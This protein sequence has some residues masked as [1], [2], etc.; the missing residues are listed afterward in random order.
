MF[1]P[2]TS[3]SAN[4]TM[5]CTASGTALA[6]QYMNIGDVTAKDPDGNDL[7][8]D[9]PSHY[10]GASS[11]INI[12]KTTNG[13]DADEPPGPTIYIGDPVNWSYV[14]T[15]TGNVTLTNIGVCD[16]K[17]VSVFC[18]K[19]ELAAGGSMTCTASG[20]ALPGQY[21]NIGS[22]TAKDPDNNSLIDYDPSHY[23]GSC[24]GITIE[25]QTNGNDADNP[26]GPSITIGYPV[27]WTYIVTNTGNVTMSDISVCDTKGVTVTCP[28]TELAAGE[29]M[30]CTASGTAQSGQYANIGKVR[31][32]DP[33]GN[34]FIDCDPSHYFGK[35]PCLQL[36]KSINGPY[37]TSDNKFLTDKI[38]PVAYTDHG[39]GVFY[40]LVTITVSNCGEGAL[41]GVEV[42]DTFSNQAYPFETNDPANV[43]I[44]PAHIPK[45]WAQETLTCSVGTLQAGTDRTLEI[46]VGTEYNNAGQLPPLGYGQTIFYN[47]KSSGHKPTAT[48]DGGLSVSVNSV[49]LKNQGQITCVGSD[50]DWINDAP[51]CTTM[52][53]TLPI[54][55]TNTTH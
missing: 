18:P 49:K 47:G 46:K 10:F 15:N 37:R 53:T 12:E 6:G 25:K 28:K 45:V 11:G 35:E 52:I 3:L 50:G 42:I 14:V 54:T 38:I 39:E 26:P 29:P 33:D 4:E 17:S 40:F 13:Q 20:S 24:P 34:D 31:A 19:T 32:K 22:V 55:Q 2:K 16:N 23:F 5:T 27:N 36:T 51:E 30:T 9:D 44:V 1:C 7:M 41:T 48:A 8:D 21:E 43:T